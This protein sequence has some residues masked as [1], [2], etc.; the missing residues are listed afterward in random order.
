MPS[1]EDR[2][3]ATGT[4]AENLVKFGLW[5]LRHTSGQT[6]RQTDRQTY[7]HVDY[8]TSH[9]TGGEVKIIF[10]EPNGWPLEH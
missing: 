5:L 9:P 10:L 4:G 3:T 8:N 2:V 1:D 7:R 6:D